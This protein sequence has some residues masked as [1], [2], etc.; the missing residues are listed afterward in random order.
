MK[1]Y[2]KYLKDS[3]KEVR[4]ALTKPENYIEHIKTVL[5]DIYGNRILNDDSKN[6]SAG[7][8]AKVC[9]KKEHLK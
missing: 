8:S 6:K 7:G 2:M 5:N 9:E 4:P 3:D 1:A